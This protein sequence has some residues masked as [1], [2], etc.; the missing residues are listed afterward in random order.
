[1]SF[2]R[3]AFQSPGFQVD[4]VGQAAGLLPELIGFATDEVRGSIAAALPELSGSAAGNVPLPEVVDLEASFVY[5]P[6]VETSG[7]VA[8]MLPKLEGAAEGESEAAEV[9]GA[10]LARLPDM[11]A[12]ATGTAQHSRLGDVL[13]APGV[14]LDLVG[15]APEVLL[16]PVPAASPEL[17]KRPRIGSVSA[18]LP[19]LEAMARGRHEAISD[20]EVLAL[21][22]AA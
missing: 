4:R 5:V 12:R 7:T 2:Q 15:P 11:T 8:A 1:M 16:E 19:R 13:T 20:E 17:V 22:V 3:G 18:S 9:V 6:P 14:L 10:A 21:L